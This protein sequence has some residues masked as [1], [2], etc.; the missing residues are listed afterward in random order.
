[1]PLRVLEPVAGERARHELD[2]AVEQLIVQA[3]LLGDPA[4]K[5]PPALLAMVDVLTPNESEARIL[6]IELNTK[7]T[8]G[9]GCRECR[10]TGYMGRTA[11][12]EVMRVN[13]QLRRALVEGASLDR[14]RDIAGK[15]GM[16]TLREA[17]VN[18]V[19]EG[20]TTVEELVRA[21]AGGI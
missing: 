18:K 11:I 16:K 19:L 9:A 10:N 13:E 2:H 21:T 14:V 20:V 5:L 6:G 7:L 15:S 12:Y 4:Q 8:R 17:A 1:M 3:L